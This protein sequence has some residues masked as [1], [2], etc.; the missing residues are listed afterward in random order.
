MQEYLGLLIAAA[1]SRIKQV[2]LAQ[3]AQF[4]LAPQQ[5]WMLVALREHPGL[6][7]AALAERVRADAPTVSRTLAALLE[8]GLVR[9][10]PDPE[11]RRRSCVF[12]TPA[13]ERLAG[14]VAAVAEGVRN[15][16]VDGMSPAEQA[17]VRRGLK[18]I[19]ENLD[20]Y[21]AQ[22]RGRRA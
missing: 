9:S 15:A 1:R 2:V 14:E 20:R 11:D 4:G 8:R 10:E 21:E 12:L 13:G 22:V 6:S 5:F 18:R 7:Q 19:L 16:V 17:T 3:V